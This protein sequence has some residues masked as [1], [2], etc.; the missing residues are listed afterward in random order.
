MY[1]LAGIIG[2]ANPVNAALGDT[3]AGNPP[4]SETAGTPATDPKSAM[5]AKVDC[6]D[7]SIGEP[8]W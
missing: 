6:V 1:G 7:D 5:P 8:V 2:F 4:M 3:T